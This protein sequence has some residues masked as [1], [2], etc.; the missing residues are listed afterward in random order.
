MRFCSTSG[1]FR[2]NERSWLAFVLI[3]GRGLPTHYGT[4]TVRFSIG[5]PVVPVGRRVPVPPFDGR[6]VIGSAHDF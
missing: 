2:V 3:V 5:F 4:T 6:M 1:L